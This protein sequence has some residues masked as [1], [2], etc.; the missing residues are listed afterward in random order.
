MEPKDTYT[1]D[2][3][4]AITFAD[5]QNS[6]F[7]T[8][9]E[10]ELEKDIQDILV[11][12]TDAERHGVITVLKLFTKYELSVGN[13]YWGSVIKE[14]FPRPDIQRMASCFEFFELNVHAP[15]Y[16][17]INEHLHLN[18]DE[19]YSSYIE[20]PILK[21]RMDF[22]DGALNDNDSLYSIGVFSL[23]EGAILYS[24]FAYL[25]HFQSQGKNKLKNLVA[26]INFSVRDENIHST[27]G[28]WLFRTLLHETRL[29]PEEQNSL[30]ERIYNAADKVREHEHQIVD[31][32]FSGGRVEGITAHQMKNFVDSRIDLCLQNL[33]LSERYKPAS[34]PIGEWFYMGISQTVIHDFFQAIGNQYHRDWSEEAFTWETA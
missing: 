30:F 22:I 1:F 10:I 15:F 7:W 11:N 23:V 2:Y 29:T 16:N 3:P 5:E 32:I 19:F 18:T 4:Q 25:K 12:M 27:A 8:H 21:S 24:N 14:K 20:D 28:A 9:Q 31:M 33:G 17:K 6:V 26:G 34:N 13:E